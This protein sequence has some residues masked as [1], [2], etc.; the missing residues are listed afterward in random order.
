M[1]TT[2]PPAIAIIGGGF[3][4]S[5]TAVQLIRQHRQPLR[6]L[7]FNCRYPVARGIAY[8]TYSD[9]HLLNVKAG[10]MSAIDGEPDH[11]VNWFLQQA[12]GK[13]LDPGQVRSCSSR[14]RS[15]AAT[16]PT[17]SNSN[18]SDCHPA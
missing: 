1:S 14:D 7:L 17:Y 15:M 18:S 16:S 12:E 5:F 11:F 13:G 10:N 8:D 4:G 9:E 2:S 6:I 3:S